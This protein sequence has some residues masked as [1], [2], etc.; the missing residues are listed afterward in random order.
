MLFRSP[1]FS[2]L[3]FGEMSK[4]DIRDNFIEF[5][6]YRDKCKYRDCM[7]DKEDDCEVKDRVKSGDILIS[8]YDNYINFISKG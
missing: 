1:G 8:R 7:H 5:N 4:G 6:T 3:N 2:A